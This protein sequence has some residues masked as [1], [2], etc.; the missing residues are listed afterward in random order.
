VVTILNKDALTALK[1]IPD[2]SVDCCV[3]SPPYFGLRIYGC[4][5]V[6]GGDKNCK[7][8]FDFTEGKVELQAGSEEFKR[9]W[10]ENASDSYK[11]GFCKCGAWYGELGQEPTPEFYIDHLVEIFGEVKR[12]LKPSG[13]IWVNIGDSYW[14]SG[15]GFGY[16]DFNDKQ[17]SNK[18]ALCYRE[19]KPSTLSEHPNLKPKDL[20]GIPWMLAFALRDRLG[21]WLRNDICW[22]KDN[23]L[24]EAVRDR[25]TRSHEYIFFLAKASKYY[26]DIEAIKEPI[27]DSSLKRISQK[28]FNTQTGGAKDFMNNDINTNRS[29]RKTVENF[30]ESCNGLR[31]KRDVWSLPNAPNRED[32]YAS[33][34]QALIEPCVKAGCPKECCAKCGAP[35]V[36][37]VERQ[38]GQSTE[39]PK[40]L[41]A[42]LARGG[43][44]TP[45]GT[46]G[47]SGS[48]RINGTTKTIGFEPSCACKYTYKSI[49]IP[50]EGENRGRREGAMG[51][52]QQKVDRGFNP[53]CICNTD[54]PTGTIKGVVIDPFGGSGTTSI[55]A[56][57]QYK[58][59]I[60][61]EPNKKYVEIAKR[62]LKREIGMFLEIKEL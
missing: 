24:P 14:G 46:V 40:T 57:K 56:E 32:H 34:S 39:C 52:G 43:T 62:R 42:H 11:S 38:A 53:S 26:F 4:P 37:V 31:Q 20:I 18:G 25:L 59:S 28:S 16:T 30:A 51:Y 54:T 2:N 6:W 58:D 12:V 21:L 47:K 29:A 1:D 33:Y 41:G 3:T 27:K 44:G 9:P 23:P 55:V 5:M 49:G 50:G 48:G 19:N 45:T 61:I 17:G 10:R 8:D 22:S 13:T 35:Y 7:H 60:L 36:R 15:K